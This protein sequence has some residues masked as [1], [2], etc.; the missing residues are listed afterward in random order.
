L[1][2]IGIGWAARQIRIATLV[3]FVFFATLL[4]SD[5][6]T[7]LSQGV[8]LTRAITIGQAAN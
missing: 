6:A 2:N 7:R 4:V 5:D 8:V 1:R 3:Q